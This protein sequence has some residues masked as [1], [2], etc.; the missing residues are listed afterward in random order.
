MENANITVE[1]VILRSVAPRKSAVARSS[2]APAAFRRV[3]ELQ[4]SAVAGGVRRLVA[5]SLEALA[6]A[7]AVVIRVRGVGRTQRGI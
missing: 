4:D 3:G 6:A 2:H 7:E 5:Q 1:R